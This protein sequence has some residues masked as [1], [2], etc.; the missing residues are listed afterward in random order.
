M[1]V[2]GS[3]VTSR[4]TRGSIAGGGITRRVAARC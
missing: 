3:V 2:A 4:V 1:T